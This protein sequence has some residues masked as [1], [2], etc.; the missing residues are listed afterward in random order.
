MP[1]FELRNDEERVRFI[2]GHDAQVTVFTYTGPDDPNDKGTN[3]TMP[4]KVARS[5]W[6]G[7][8]SLGYWR[9]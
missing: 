4:L 9:V 2:P 8:L 1:V 3:K 6:S 5:Y 7:L